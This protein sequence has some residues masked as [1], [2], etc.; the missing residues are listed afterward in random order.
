MLYCT[1]AVMSCKVSSP[2]EVSHITSNN[3][4]FYKKKNLFSIF[5]LAEKL[6]F[7]QYCTF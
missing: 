4:D 6:H 2:C 3:S 5:L 7:I 1:Q